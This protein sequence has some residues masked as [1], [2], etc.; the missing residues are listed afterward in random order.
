[1]EGDRVG[2]H[3]LRYL[4]LRVVDQQA[5]DRQHP[6]EDAVVIDHEQFVGVVGQ[7]FQAA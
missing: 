2:R 1:M 4:L 6:L 5:L 7:L 3:D